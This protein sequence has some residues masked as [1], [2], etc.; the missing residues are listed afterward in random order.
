MKVDKNGLK[1][2]IFLY[3]TL[4]SV[5][6]LA[7]LWA[8]QFLL[9][10]RFYEGMKI[11]ELVRTGED[12]VQQ[13]QSPTFAQDMQRIAF[14]QNLR[15]IL[16][17]DLGE[18][19]S[20]ADTFF[21]PFQSGLARFPVEDLEAILKEFHKTAGNA[22][23]YGKRD[24]NGTLQQ[25]IYVAKVSD[26]QNAVY[27]LYVSAAV[28]PID[29][30]VS[31]LRTQF[32]IVTVILLVLSLGIS[33]FISRKLSV[34]IVRLTKSAEKLAEGDLSL[35]IQ[36]EEY[37]ELNQLASTLQYA[38]QELS[39]LDTYRKEFIANVSHDLKTPLTI[40]KF[41]GEMIRDISGENPEKRRQ[42]SELIVKEADWLAGMVSEILELSR[43]ESGNAKPETECFD[44]SA[45]V[46]ETLESFRALSDK[47][48]YRFQT[49]IT[50][51]CFVSGSKLYLKRAL[52]NL[53][54]NAVNY[55]GE[56]KTV[57]VTLTMQN[58]KLRFS[59][60]DSG[61]GIAQ[62]KLSTIWDR[63]YKDG[64]TH[65]RAV[66]GT[67]LGLSI[68]KQVMQ[69]HSAVYGVNSTPQ[70]GSTFWFELP[71]ATPPREMESE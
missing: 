65:R 31:V 47:E 60:R 22:V 14:Q 59:V 52:Y 5:V 42:H 15:I 16:F 35:Q 41:Y 40:I 19:Y 11:A 18:T 51:G 21:T 71:R 27:Y 69:L 32:I 62:E 33:V 4:F 38:A 17:D 29:S 53:M 45:A 70:E 30:T 50:D 44:L 28:P 43:L 63:Y 8:L 56:D 55:T 58:G 66:V 64:E 34:P 7:L 24:A 13:F 39:K 9:L 36:K 48:G 6:I 37:T 54:S 46:W 10:D 20:D 3:F 1:F 57:A 61:E 68:V 12:I 49:Q 23:H 25:I 26:E 2:Q 67:G